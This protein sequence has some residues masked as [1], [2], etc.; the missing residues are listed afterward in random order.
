VA[1]LTKSQI[2]VNGSLEILTEFIDVGAF[3][4]NGILAQDGR[5]VSG[6]LFILVNPV[7]EQYRYD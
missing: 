7:S 1:S 4:G 2:V 6:T 3:I 5:E